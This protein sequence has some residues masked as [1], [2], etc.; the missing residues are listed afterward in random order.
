MIH[1]SLFD[2]VNVQLH[3]DVLPANLDKLP[4]YRLTLLT[5]QQQISSELGNIA[6]HNNPSE[7]VHAYQRELKQLSNIFFD[8][9]KSLVANNAC[10]HPVDNF[11]AEMATGYDKLLGELL[12]V[13]FKYLRPH[14]LA[15]YS[16]VSL[17]RQELR[18]IVATI[19]EQAQNKKTDPA[20]LNLI[21]NSVAEIIDDEKKGV[22]QWLLSYCQEL[23]KSLLRA[24]DNKYQI[25]YR[26]M[27]LNFNSYDFY[28]YCREKLRSKL[29]GLHD[30]ASRIALLSSYERD[31]EAHPVLFEGIAF[32]LDADPW[33]TLILKRIAIEKKFE[34]SKR[35]LDV[36]KAAPALSNQEKE[37]A[38]LNLLPKL[39]TALNVNQLAL[40]VRA[41][42]DVGIITNMSVTDIR[43][44]ITGS[45]TTKRTD[46]LAS[47]SFKTKYYNPEPATILECQQWLDKVQKKLAEYDT[48][49]KSK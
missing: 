38:I 36:K 20:L 1:A 29:D 28:I 22:T 24:T 33:A 45:L 40:M 15:P 23:L 18:S 47:S 41:Y 5:N 6:N 27:H 13:H 11:Y 49:K 10:H 9:R 48:K 42:K 16:Y 30:S 19:R 37:R 25:Y 12:K 2:M 17:L 32:D 8:L 34:E 3:P 43:H 4:A 44:F 46:D 26:L 39:N 21:L 31:I 14:I 7:I 35:D